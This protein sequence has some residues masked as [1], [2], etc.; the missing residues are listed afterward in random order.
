MSNLFPLIPLF[1]CF[2]YD[3]TGL[4]RARAREKEGDLVGKGLFYNTKRGG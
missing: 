4:A 2:R 3:E 1:S